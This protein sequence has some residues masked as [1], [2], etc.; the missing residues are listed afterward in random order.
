MSQLV[1]FW[2][3]WVSAIDD[4]PEQEVHKRVVKLSPVLENA[5]PVRDV[6]RYGHSFPL[7]RAEHE[8]IVNYVVQILAGGS[9][10]QK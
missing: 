10:G 6:E 5:A 9:A 3:L 1:V 4:M 2:Y 7:V 8:H